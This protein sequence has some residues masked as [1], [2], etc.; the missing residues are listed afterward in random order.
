MIRTTYPI[1][2]LFTGSIQ[3]LTRSLSPVD[4]FAVEG[5]PATLGVPCFRAR[6]R[7]SILQ[8]V[9]SLDAFNTQRLVPAPF[10][11]FCPFH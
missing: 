2:A 7:H 4:R 9:S 1:L 3:S 6:S 11:E 5:S 8:P 10:N